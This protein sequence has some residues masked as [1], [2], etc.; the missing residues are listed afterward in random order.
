MNEEYKKKIVK[1]V[2]KAKEDCL[3]GIYEN[4]LTTDDY[5]EEELIDMYVAYFKLPRKKQKAR[6]RKNQ[7]AKAQAELDAA[8]Y[9]SMLKNK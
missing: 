7:K 8:I 2:L 5:S 4:Q 6:K 1:A 3:N 9:F